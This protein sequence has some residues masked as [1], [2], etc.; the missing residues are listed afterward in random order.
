MKPVA[1]SGMI[2]FKSIFK[3]HAILCKH[4]TVLWDHRTFPQFTQT[5]LHLESEILRIF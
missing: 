2:S 5:R 3:K 1:K 4:V